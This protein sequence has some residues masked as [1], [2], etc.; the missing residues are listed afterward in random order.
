M[1][2]A[3]LCGSNG[4]VS[5]WRSGGRRFDPRRVWQDS[6]VELDHGIF[7]MVIVSL[8]LIQEGHLSVSSANTG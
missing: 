4:C 7:S 3:G 5:D 6:F 1:N 8:L 2:R